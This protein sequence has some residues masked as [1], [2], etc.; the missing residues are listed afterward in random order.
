M[1]EY[2]LWIQV[3]KKI[4]CAIRAINSGTS[5][6]KISVIDLH[7]A[8]LVTSLGYYELH[9]SYISNSAY[10]K[11]CKYMLTNYEKFKNQVRYPKETLEVL[12]LVAGTGYNIKYPSAIHEIANAYRRLRYGQE[13]VR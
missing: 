13:D 12:S 5:F 11:I 8:Y 4:D 10:D 2:E 7:T 9:E 3:A 1:N 6:D